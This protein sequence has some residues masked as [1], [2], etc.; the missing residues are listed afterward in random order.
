M[1]AFAGM[2]RKTGW[3]TSTFQLLADDI[4]AELGDIFFLAGL[5][6]AL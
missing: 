2:M 6:R 3:H 5:R 1:P 4:Q